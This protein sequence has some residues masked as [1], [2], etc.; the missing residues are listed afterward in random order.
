[1]ASDD[2]SALLTHLQHKSQC[3][4]LSDLHDRTFAGS[5]ARTIQTMQRGDFSPAA[6]RGAIFYITGQ[7]IEEEETEELAS[8]LICWLERKV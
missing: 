5:I 2:V 1:M 3:G 7:R 8:R 4:Y 6:W